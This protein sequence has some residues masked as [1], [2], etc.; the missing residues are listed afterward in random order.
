MVIQ[1]DN[2][3]MCDFTPRCDLYCELEFLVDGGSGR[4][5]CCAG[6]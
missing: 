3:L 1:V 2:G 4:G 5:T 6:R